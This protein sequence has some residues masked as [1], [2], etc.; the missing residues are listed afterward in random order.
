MNTSSARLRH[1][2][3]QYLTTHTR[4]EAW[5]NRAWALAGG[6]SV[7]TKILGIV[8][9]L[10]TVLGL[11][12]TWQVRT[13]M[14]HVFMA[15]LQNRGES[16]VSDLAARS[17]DPILLNDT[18][19]LYELL[20]D[21]VA[22]H[23]DAVYAFVVDNSGQVLAHTF[24][25]AGFP[26]E[27][28][29]LNQPGQDSAIH[30]LQYL[31]N[32]GHIHDFAAPIFEGRA[33]MVRLGL[34][35]TRLHGIVNSV[36]GQMLL[37]TLLVA[38]AGIAAAILLTWLLT[39]PILTLVETTREVG[40]GNLDVEAPHWADD[41]IGTLAD[42]FNQMVADLK[43]S[44][45]AIAEKDAARTRLL[46]QLINAQEEERKRIARELHDGVG[47]AL[48]SLLV[49]IKVAGQAETPEAIRRK[50]DQVRQI[51]A[52]TLE[53]V[54]LLSRQLRPSVLDDLGLAAALERYVEEFRQLY[55]AITVDLHCDLPVRL[56]APTET[57]LYRIIQ[58]AM[59]NA[60]RHGD[61]R[62]VS[63]LVSRRNDHV[64]AIIEDD[65]HGFDPV[66]ARRAGHSVGIHGMIERA[67]LL[68]G[69]VDIESSPEG[70]TVYVE[71]P[72]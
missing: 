60:A 12:I 68:G 3:S 40:R 72:A 48:T 14:E 11:G 64:Q 46:E 36:T 17:V 66:A 20:Q 30:H 10:T 57:T 51:A 37:T 1:W 41:E 63:V 26:L 39:R 19:A 54:R 45:Q 31:S 35:E 42:A 44:R 58:E 71:V 43:A 55:P 6:V 22:N 21:T 4:L 67:E 65:G 16:V 52:E 18:Y 29:G 9:A 7:R 24:G 53:Q 27:L 69:R 59:T 32:Q 33:G 13:V 25:D 49:G 15:E 56:S 50:H 23:P 5:L 70:T 62:M 2:P 47:Q 38:L 8:L 34:S 28:L 61:G